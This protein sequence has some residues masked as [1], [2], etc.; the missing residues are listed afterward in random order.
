MRGFL[1]PAVGI[2]GGVPCAGHK[3]KA[4]GVD[5]SLCACRQ[6]CLDQEHAPNE[7]AG[8]GDY[9]DHGDAGRFRNRVVVFN[10]Y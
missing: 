4:T 2:F 7:Y 1:Y 6:K 9:A 3:K 5:R 8:S 10:R